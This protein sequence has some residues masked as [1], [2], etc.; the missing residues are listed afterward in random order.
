M[1]ENLT[2]RITIRISRSEHDFLTAEEKKRA[3]WKGESI[4]AKLIRS[5]LHMLRLKMEAET[6]SQPSLA[7]K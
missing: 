3:R 7:L 5:A 4:K 1:S 6:K 2:H